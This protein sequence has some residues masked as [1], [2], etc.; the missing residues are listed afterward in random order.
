VYWG[1]FAGQNGRPNG[2]AQVRTSWVPNGRSGHAGNTQIQL[3]TIVTQAIAQLATGNIGNAWTTVRGLYAVGDSF[4]TKLVMFMD[5]SQCVVL[6]N[7]I[8]RNLTASANPVLASIRFRPSCYTDWCDICCQAAATLNSAGHQWTDWDGT[9]HSWRAVDVER[10][11]FA[12][13]G[14]PMNLFTAVNRLPNGS[15]QVI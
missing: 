6:D 13:A 10:A 15:I 1:F 4:A 14:D 9:T 11:A 8:L 3:S 2:Y 7:V 12:H 5:P